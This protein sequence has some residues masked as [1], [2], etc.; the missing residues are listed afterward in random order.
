[1][2]FFRSSSK[3]ASDVEKRQTKQIVQPTSERERAPSTLRARLGIR[4]AI[5]RHTSRSSV[6]SRTSASESPIVSTL[7][8][9]SWGAKQPRSP[10]QPALTVNISC[11]AALGPCRFVT[12]GHKLGSGAYGSVL[13]G[14]DLCMSLP[15]AIK[16]IPEGRMRPQSLEREV[17]M[18][19]RLSEV[20]HPAL[21]RFFAH[22]RP[23]EIESG[24]LR[25]NGEQLPLQRS[26]SQYHALVMEVARGGELFERVVK[27]DGLAERE[28][29]PICAQLC[30]AVRAAHSLGIAH[31]DLK[32]ENV[33]LV[34]RGDSD[35]RR[36]KLVDWGLA[37]QH[38]LNP[39]G[40]VIH[41]RLHSRCG[42]RSYM[43]PEVSNRELS[44]KVGYNGF[45]ADVWSL[46][47]C[48]FAIHLGFFPFEQADAEQD[49]RARRV[50]TAQREGRSTMETILSFYP[51]RP[52]R[53]SQPLLALIDRML[54]FD[55]SERAS[56]A[57]VLSSE[58]LAPHVPAVSPMAL[59]L[60]CARVNTATVSRMSDSTCTSVTD[61][62][63]E[64]GGSNA[65]AMP[66]Q[67]RT[68]ARASP[69][70]HGGRPYAAPRTMC[71]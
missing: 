62:Q 63:S 50:V 48:L 40:S 60:A 56:L 6:G 68:G 59:D 25:T 69:R 49:W 42:S 8:S 33:L 9:S 54:V 70:L 7:H 30:D 65:G 55:P 45:A 57:E 41:E 32:L 26:I 27:V 28:S 46:G 17:S 66:T 23:H 19:R 39:D 38:A 29:A 22:V 37:H 71:L 21:V 1:M 67:P 51:Q 14:T 44:A 64:F 47:V 5:K 35:F 31:R 2:P 3:R 24:E 53:L 11:E 52:L 18:L 13:L 16:F 34:G 15:V 12:S 43:A 4:S 10:Q 20:N 61:N 36:I 58:W